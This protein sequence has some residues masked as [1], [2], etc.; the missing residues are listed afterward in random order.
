MHEKDHCDLCHCWAFMAHN[1]YL[2]LIGTDENSIEFLTPT[3]PVP[4]VL[5][6]HL[7]CGALEIAFIL[8]GRFGGFM[9]AHG[10]DLPAETP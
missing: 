3:Q 2:Y 5:D 1:G 7:E 8:F 6:R 4:Y 9:E 10:F